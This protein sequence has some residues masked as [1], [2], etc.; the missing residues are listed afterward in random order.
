MILDLVFIVLYLVGVIRTVI[1]RV[2]SQMAFMAQVK[3]TCTS[4]LYSKKK[5]AELS[6]YF[7]LSNSQGQLPPAIIDLLGLPVCITVFK[8]QESAFKHPGEGE[9]LYNKVTAATLF[10]I[11][12]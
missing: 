5:L 12:N 6:P 1:S 3:N 4:H 8:M 7:L 10:M 2:N 9:C 11:L